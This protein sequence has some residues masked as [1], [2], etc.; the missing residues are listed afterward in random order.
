MKLNRNKRIGLVL[1]A[2]CLAGYF[3]N[4]K[5]TNFGFVFGAIGGI[6]GALMLIGEAGNDR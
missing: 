3:L 1:L 2:V 5:G 6:G 4:D